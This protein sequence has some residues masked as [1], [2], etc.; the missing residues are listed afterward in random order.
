V[1][2]GPAL[3]PGGGSSYAQL[4]SLMERGA[5]VLLDAGLT[6]GDKVLL[7]LEPC[8]AWPIA[9]FSILEAGLIAVPLPVETPLATAAGVAAFAGARA[10]IVSHRTRGLAV[11]DGLRC[12]AVEQLLQTEVSVGRGPNGATTELALLAFTSGSTQ[13]PRAVELTHASILA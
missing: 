13:K 12:I 5:D 10:A 11:G 3:S 6:L 4:R 2:L 7:F 9:F 8:P 1:A